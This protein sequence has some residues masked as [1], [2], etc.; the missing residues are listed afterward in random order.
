[1]GISC[2]K[3][4]KDFSLEFLMSQDFGKDFF[5]KLIFPKIINKDE[6]LD[7]NTLPSKIQHLKGK[8]FIIDD[9]SC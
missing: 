5:R 6:F 2:F 7:T 8:N 9:K 1:M 4:S 3:C